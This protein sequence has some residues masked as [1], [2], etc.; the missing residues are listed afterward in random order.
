MNQ[1]SN[2]NMA[3]SIIRDVFLLA[4]NLKAEDA[5]L[6]TELEG[7]LHDYREDERQYR[8]PCLIFPTEPASVGEPMP[9]LR[10]RDGNDNT[11]YINSKELVS[12][13][14]HL[15]QKM[16]ASTNSN[17]QFFKE[18]LLRKLESRAAYL[19]DIARQQWFSKRVQ[20][21]IA[22]RHIK[23]ARR[24]IRSSFIY[25][26]GLQ[27]TPIPLLISVLSIL[28]L[29]LL[30][31]LPRDGSNFLLEAM[32]MTAMS[33]LLVVGGLTGYNTMHLQQEIRDS[34]AS[35]IR[36]VSKEMFGTE[37]HSGSLRALIEPHRFSVRHRE[38]VDWHSVSSSTGSIHSDGPLATRQTLGEYT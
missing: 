10:N 14:L 24:T 19:E 20:A 32:Q 21:E 27:A 35:D 17:V 38:N 22:R 25:P 15:V 5:S 29:F 3:H 33:T 30:Q 12:R 23:Q 36:T 16:P 7:Y 1:S 18:S 31:A 8:H 34:W 26:T 2:N 37:K 4:G 9:H 13:L 28:S 6:Y 11:D